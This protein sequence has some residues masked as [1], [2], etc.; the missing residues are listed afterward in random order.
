MNK[1]Y[2]MTFGRKYD[3]SEVINQDK[4]PITERESEER[5]DL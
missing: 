3:G 4:S 5:S 2:R 1:S